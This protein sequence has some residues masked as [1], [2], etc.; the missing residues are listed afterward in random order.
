MKRKKRPGKLIVLILSALLISVLSGCGKEE[1]EASPKDEMSGDIKVVLTMGELEQ[2]LFHIGNTTCS[3]EEYTLY[4]VNILNGTEKVYGTDIFN[5]KIIGSKVSDRIKELAMSRIAQIK[6]M[7]VLAESYSVSLTPDEEKIAKEAAEEY[8]DSLNDSEK[9]FLNLDEEG[10]FKCYKEYAI[11]H[12]VY[13]Y[14]I[15]DINPEISDDEA[16]SVTVEYIFLRGDEGDPELINK[17]N[18][19]YRQA[20][21]SEDFASLAVTYS[22]TRSLTKSFGK[23]EEAKVMEDTAFSLGEGEVSLPFYCENGYYILHMLS[24]YDKDETE[25]NKI[26][27]LARRKKE[28]FNEVYDSFARDQIIK[29]DRQQYDEVTI[30]SDHTILTSSFFDIYDEHFKDYFTNE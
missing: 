23:E 17:A 16:R 8:Y 30:P 9:A 14:V 18:E 6:M 5:Q 27:I 29:L 22:D 26:K 28:A 11:A 21:I 4:L 12:K 15:R 13:A 19:V 3:K 7:N 1:K 24:T 20:L 10:I 25:N 2:G